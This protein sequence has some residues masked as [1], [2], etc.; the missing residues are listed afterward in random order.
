VPADLAPA[1]DEAFGRLAELLADLRGR[2]PEGHKAFLAGL[3]WVVEHPAYLVVHAGLTDKPFAGQLAALRRRDFADTRPRWLHGR[4]DRTPPPA[5]CPQVV[6]SGHTKVPAVEVRHGGRMILVDTFG[7]Y[8]S[9]LSAVL[10][11]E[12]TVVTSEG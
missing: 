4:P 5:D 10:L 2:M 6:V 3:P 8:G 9:V 7:G 12:M 11:P 1:R